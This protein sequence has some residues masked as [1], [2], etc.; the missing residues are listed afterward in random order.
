VPRLSLHPSGVGGGQGGRR[1]PRSLSRGQS[2]AA[3]SRAAEEQRR[4]GGAEQRKSRGGAAEQSS[5]RAEAERHSGAATEALLPSRG[6][7]ERGW[8]GPQLLPPSPAMRPS[9]GAEQHDGR[10]ERSGAA[11]AKRRSRGGAAEQSSRECGVEHPARE[12]VVLLSVVTPRSGDLFKT[13]K[14]LN[15][16]LVAPFPTPPV[17]CYSCWSNN[18]KI[19][20]P[21]PRI[22][23]CK[24]P[25]Y[26]GVPRVPRGTP[27]YPGI[28]RVSWGTP[29]LSAT[30]PSS[31][32]KVPQQSATVHSSP[33]TV[34]QRTRAAMIF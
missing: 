22:S 26:P 29:G 31:A 15:I 33:A 11:E 24:A 13:H 10:V 7:S 34:A 18:I 30:V 4:S 5:G 1:Y 12:Y 6:T 28:P 9:G 19:V 23:I 32:E 3:K 14:Y 2:R 8:R 17:F 25:G 21:P 16:F 20:G 27:G